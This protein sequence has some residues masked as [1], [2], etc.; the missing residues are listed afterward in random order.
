MRQASPIST[1]TPISLINPKKVLTKHNPFSPL[2]WGA[3]GGLLLALALT[4]CTRAKTDWDMTGQDTVPAAQFAPQP[5]TIPLPDLRAIT[6][7]AFPHARIAAQQP[8]TPDS[9]AATLDDESPASGNYQLTLALDTALTDSLLAQVERRAQADTLWAIRDHA[10]R[11]ERK[12]KQALW[13]ITF[14]KGAK[15]INVTRRKA[16]P[17][18]R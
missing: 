15:T 10:Y 6:G 16:K 18:S 3:R 14:E 13:T 9:L 4:A 5:D 2:P 7:V 12:D 8:L 1:T 17:A 11:Y